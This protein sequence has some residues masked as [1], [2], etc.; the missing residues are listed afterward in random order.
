MDP[1]WYM[2]VSFRRELEQQQG[3]LVCTET[4]R[5]RLRG[6]ESHP[7]LQERSL[8]CRYSNMHPEVA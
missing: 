6:F 4:L 3:T 7:R 5:T 1:Y 8:A 2:G